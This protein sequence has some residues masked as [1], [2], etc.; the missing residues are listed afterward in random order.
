MVA[1]MKRGRSQVLWRYMPGAT[2][3]YNENGPWSRTTEITLRDTGALAGAL[4][5]AVDHELRRWNAI[6]PHA[7]PD[8]LIQSQRYEVGTPAQVFYTMWPTVFV[9]RRCRRAHWYRD[10]ATLRNSNEQ[11]R[12]RSCRQPYLLRQVPYAYVCECGR[13]DNV[14]IPRHDSGHTIE[15]V[16]KKGFQESY[17]WCKECQR[18]LY[19]NP[20]EGLGFRSCECAPRKAKRGILLQDPRVYFSQTVD[21]V[22]L[23]PS[24]MERWQGHPRF[25]DLLLAAALRIPTYQAVHLRDLATWKPPSGELSPELQAMRD[26]LLQQGLP[27]DRVDGMIQQSAR[28]AAADP[29][30]PYDADLAP[31]RA[32]IGTGDW[33]GSRQT[34]EYVFVR[35]EPT[36]VAVSLDDLIAEAKTFGDTSL[37]QRLEHEKGLA[38]DLGLVNMKVVQA[39]PITL[40]AI[41]YTR[42]FGTPQDADESG[43]TNARPV[44]LRPFESPNGRIPIFV[45]RNTTEAFLYELDPWRVAAFLEVNVGLTAPTNATTSEP[46]I[47]TWLARQCAPL[48]NRGESHLILRQYEIESGLTVDEASALVF[49]VL[50]SVSHILKATAQ[51]YV[52]IDSDTLAEYLFPAHL[53]GLLYV[54]T[55]VEFTLGGIDSVIRSNLTQ[56]LGSARDYAGHCS[57]DPVCSRAGGACPVCLYPKFGCDYFNR[58]VSRAFLFGGEVRG[59]TNP[60]VGYWTAAVS[61]A[62][63]RIKNLRPSISGA[64]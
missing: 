51:R 13:L 16:D 33:A 26:L 54:S 1:E 8:P 18:P 41:G 29:W 43:Q 4:A 40:A 5:S 58:T 57:F 37:S 34:I 39:L 47:R 28:R 21:L 17:W 35:D 63:P 14:Y 22:D 62:V 45:A 44:E 11:L 9:C 48:F 61:E 25:S 31:H 52:G 2:F 24:M 53:A 64:N 60:V 46:A 7:Y 23:A 15:L 3:R 12:C 27:P 20:R 55:H 10:L 6:G 49:G 59:R 32:T 36:M 38:A 50:H 56:W 19:R 42:Y 30:A